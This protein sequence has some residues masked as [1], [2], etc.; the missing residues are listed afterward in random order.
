[1]KGYGYTDND[2]FALHIRNQ[3]AALLYKRQVVLKPSWDGHMMAG[4]VLVADQDLYTV[5]IADMVKGMQ[6]FVPKK[7]LSIYEDEEGWR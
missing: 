6:P 5:Y 7:T 3:I 1:M 4:P 2:E